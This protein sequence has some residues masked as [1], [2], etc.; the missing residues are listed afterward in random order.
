MTGKPVVLVLNAFGHRAIPDL[1]AEAEFIVADARPVPQFSDPDGGRV[2]AVMVNLPGVVSEAVLERLPA[3]RIISA[4]GVGVH[5]I[6]V[7]AATRMGIPVVNQRGVG[8]EPVAEHAIG[9][10]L[11]L[12]RRIVLADTS[13]RADGWRA[14]GAFRSRLSDSFATVLKDATVGIIGLGSIGGRIAEICVRGFGMKA[15]GYSPRAAGAQFEALGMT[16]MGSVRDVCA[17][18]DYV[19]L[20]GAYRPDTHHLVTARDIGAMKPTAFFINVARG[21]MVQ[22]D[23]L[24]AALADG[25]IAGAGIDVFDPEPVEDGEPLVRLENVVVTPHVAGYAEATARLYAES[26]VRQ[27]RQVLAGRRP[28][29]LVDPSVWSRRR[30]PEARVGTADSR[31]GIPV[32]TPS[33]QAV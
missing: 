14:R 12:S 28:P 27:I 11:T 29:H 3:V 30:L 26:G 18:A 24:Y 6:D 2:D 25:R 5:N 4:A 9:L 32:G 7:E 22:Q 1:F 19:V 33:C 31:P 15:V 23:A 17:A 20:A 13:F 16:R 21:G 8:T 10:M